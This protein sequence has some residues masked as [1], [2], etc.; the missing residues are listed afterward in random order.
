MKRITA[1]IFAIICIFALAA[2]GGE[3]MPQAYDPVAT[4]TP[5]PKEVKEEIKAVEKAE[6]IGA[7]GKLFIEGTE[8]ETWSVNDV[9]SVKSDDLANAVPEDF[10]SDG[11]YFPVD[12]LEELGLGLFSINNQ[13]YYSFSAGNW[14]YPEG[15]KIPV[16]RYLGCDDN[17]WTCATE[18]QLDAA[19]QFL[20]DNYDPIWFE[21]LRK[22][23]SYE[24]PVII[25]FKFGFE[26]VYTKALPIAQKYG[27][28][29]SVAPCTGF[30]GKEGYLSAEQIQELSRSGLVAVEA[31]AKDN[32]DFYGIG[33]NGLQEQIASPK[34]V[35]AELTGKMPVAFG[36]PECAIMDE[37]RTVFSENYRFGIS[38]TENNAFNTSNSTVS[39]HPL[40]TYAGETV[41]QLAQRI[42]DSLK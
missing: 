12:S 4:P 14:D 35:I 40:Q 19:F 8:V 13:D 11:K 23:D 17:D 27:V 6:E 18:A 9:L 30:I 2:C 36:Y 24:N 16:I 15:V 25:F 21:D 31:G 28:K 33:S 1:I 37:A 34:M 7:V 32:R 20:S 42:E 26:S 10:V 3:P 29:F 22:L 41:E 5:L 38:G 39:I